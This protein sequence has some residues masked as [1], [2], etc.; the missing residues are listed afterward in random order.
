MQIWE[1][2]PQVT[3]YHFYRGRERF[4]SDESAFPCWVVLATEEGQFQYRV[5]QQKGV[6]GFGDLIL[7]RPQLS[8]WRHALSTLSYH[9]ISFH[10]RDVRGN[11]VLIKDEMPIG[12]ISI[13]DRHRLSSNFAYLSG[14]YGQVDEWSLQRRSHILRDILQ[15]Y[16]LQTIEK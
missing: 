2:T 8:F 12:K 7:C 15:L 3:N 13:K 5:Q 1:L 6:A 10:W 16:F 11:E 9:V 14:I 4:I